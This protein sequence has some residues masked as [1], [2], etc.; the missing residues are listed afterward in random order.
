MEEEKNELETQPVPTIQEKAEA[1]AAELSAQ[2]NVKVIPFV[3]KDEETG[4]DIVGFIKEPPRAVKL[5]MLDKSMTGSFTAASEV[6]E[7]ILIKEHSDP[8]IYSEKS[9]DDRFY[10]G[11]VMAAYDRVKFSINTLKKK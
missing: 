11:A 9:E 5:A 6:L 8:R 1:K 10:L 2:M 3:F 4:A 7:S